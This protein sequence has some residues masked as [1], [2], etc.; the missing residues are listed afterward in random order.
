MKF[1]SLCMSLFCAAT[2]AAALPVEPSAESA[3]QPCIP[4]QVA[5]FLVPGVP[6]ALVCEGEAQ[7]EKRDAPPPTGLG[8][9]VTSGEQVVK[10][11][12]GI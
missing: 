5:K 11:V 2:L 8:G 3:A 10:G 7:P 4:A 6:K 1:Q 9:V 12:V